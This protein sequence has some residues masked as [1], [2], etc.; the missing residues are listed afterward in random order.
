M[1]DVERTAS[2]GRRPSRPC[3]WS[4]CIRPRSCCS[5]QAYWAN[6]PVK[7]RCVV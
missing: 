5:W 7:H 6:Q 1:Q 3:R 4:W 2:L